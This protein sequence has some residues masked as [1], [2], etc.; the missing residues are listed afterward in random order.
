MSERTASI[1]LNRVLA[2]LR[3][4]LEAWPRQTCP[5]CA[6]EFR[7]EPGLCWDCEQAEMRAEEARRAAEA[8]LAGVDARWRTVTLDGYRCPPGDARARDT[9]AAWSGERG[10]YIHGTP[11]AGKSHLAFA[12]LRKS[13]RDGRSI[14]AADWAS[15]L[16]R[17]RRTFEGRGET[18]HDIAARVAQADIVLI[19]DLGA[20]KPTEWAA[21]QLWAL[22]QGRYG[23]GL[24]LIVTSN[25]PLAELAT[26]FRGADGDRVASRLVEMCE[27]VQVQAA[28]YRIYGDS[29]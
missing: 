25:L 24:P 5:A 17:I 7:G 27:R 16:R 14:F 10:L 29:K 8:I 12:L 21:E 3:A 11:G 4:T 22:V 15:Y 2:E 28:D 26:K 13:I 6:A 23:S 19:D 20:G 9:I 18:E 1:E